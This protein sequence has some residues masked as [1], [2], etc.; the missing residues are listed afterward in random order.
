VHCLIRPVLKFIL[1][2]LMI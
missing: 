1:A 2:T